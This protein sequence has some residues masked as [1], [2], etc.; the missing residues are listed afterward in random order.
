MAACLFWHI[1]NR[2]CG[3]AVEFPHT[4]EEI[5][6]CLNLSDTEALIFGP[7]FIGRMETIYD[8]IPQVKLLL[9]AGEGRPSF[10]E[11]YDRLTANCSSEAPKIELSDDDDAAIYFSS[12]TTGFPKAILHTHRSLMCACET[13]LAHMDRPVRTISCAYRPSTIQ[14]PRCTGSEA[15]CREVKP[16]CCEG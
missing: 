12:G 1:E 9:Y 15:C 13:E 14:E 7:E 3:S 10:A 16:Y 4:A 6:Y 5:K 8:K 11:S 2:C